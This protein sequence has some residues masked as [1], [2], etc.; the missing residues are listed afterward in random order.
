MD[1]DDEIR[2]EELAADLHESLGEDWHNADS[3]SYAEFADLP[4]PLKE[5]LIAGAKHI[6][7]TVIF[8]D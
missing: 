2:I 6:R 5:R 3:G 4:D 7:H 8:E 1:R